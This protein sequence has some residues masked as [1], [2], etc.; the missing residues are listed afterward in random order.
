MFYCNESKNNID[1]LNLFDKPLI[2][3]LYVIL[4]ERSNV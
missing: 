1:L 2:L 4:V 3:S